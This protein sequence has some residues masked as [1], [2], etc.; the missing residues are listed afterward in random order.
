MNIIVRLCYPSDRV[1][2]VFCT[3]QIAA[4]GIDPVDGAVRS[5]I[6]D[7]LLTGGGVEI[8]VGTQSNDDGV[9]KLSFFVQIFLQYPVP[10]LPGGTPWHR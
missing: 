8:T 4:V 2:D 9:S 6:V 5:E 7:E 1:I 3:R 10:E